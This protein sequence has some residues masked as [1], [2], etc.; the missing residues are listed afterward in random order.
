MQGLLNAILLFYSSRCLFGI[1]KAQETGTRWHPINRSSETGVWTLWTC[2]ARERNIEVIGR[3]GGIGDLLV[4]GGGSERKRK[5]MSLTLKLQLE[6]YFEMKCWPKSALKKCE[7]QMKV[8]LSILGGTF[9]F[10]KARIGLHLSKQFQSLKS[11][12]DYFSKRTRK[13]FSTLD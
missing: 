8:G 5:G 2:A 4:T 10:V 3:G 1:K 9:E 7:P 12:K 6:D 13:S 11:C